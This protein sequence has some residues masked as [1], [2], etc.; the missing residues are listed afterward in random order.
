[1]LKLKIFTKGTHN[2]IRECLY[3]EANVIK[4]EYKCIN[5]KP[6][7]QPK[8]IRSIFINVLLWTPASLSA[9]CPL[10]AASSL[11]AQAL[12]PTASSPWDALPPDVQDSL[13][14]FQADS[15][16]HSEKGLSLTT[17]IK[18]V[19]GVPSPPFPATRLSSSL[20]LVQPENNSLIGTSFS[21]GLC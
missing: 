18:S 3:Y 11:S 10:N 12:G 9:P 8:K 16:P 17:Q 6:T 4:A 1:M 2:K 20:H 7:L 13:P 21:S 14:V 5:Q 19:L 15:N